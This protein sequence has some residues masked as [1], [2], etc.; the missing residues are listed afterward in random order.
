MWDFFWSV[1]ALILVIEGFLPALSPSSW[2]NFMRLLSSQSDKTLRIAG[3]S[4]MI[5]GALL[6]VAAHHLTT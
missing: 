2:R 1:I 4:M 5:L 6:L 3:L